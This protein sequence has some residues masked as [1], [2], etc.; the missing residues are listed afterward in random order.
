MGL[1]ER[2]GLTWLRMGVEWTTHVCC[3]FM[4]QRNQGRITAGLH[5]NGVEWHSSAIARKGDLHF[6]TAEC[7]SWVL[8]ALLVRVSFARLRHV[9]RGARATKRSAF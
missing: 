3:W 1:R 2:L 8:R 6:A 7:K 5:A 4:L 9:N